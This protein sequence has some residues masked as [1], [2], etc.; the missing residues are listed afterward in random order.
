VIK[1]SKSLLKSDNLLV[2][3]GAEVANGTAC[4]NNFISVCTDLW[5]KHGNIGKRRESENLIPFAYQ[6]RTNPK[7][8]QFYSDIQR[9]ESN[10]S[11]SKL[12]FKRWFK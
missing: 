2:L 1:G 5:A 3:R 4:N 9:R 10:T 7:I 6:P 11:F 12:L 8:G